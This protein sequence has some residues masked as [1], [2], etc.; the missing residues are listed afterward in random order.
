MQTVQSVAPEQTKADIHV[1][2]DSKPVNER[3]RTLSKANVVFCKRGEAGPPDPSSNL[4]SRPAF[5]S[6]LSPLQK[7]TLRLSPM[8]GRS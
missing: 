3:K 2:S 4:D 8:R 7:L 5:A 1:E 6:K